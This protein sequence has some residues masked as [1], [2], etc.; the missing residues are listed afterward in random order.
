MNYMKQVANM[1]GVEVD[2]DFECYENSYKYK[3]TENGLVSSGCYG[4]DSLMMLL[5]GDLTIKRKPWKPQYGATYYCVCK[6]GYVRHEKWYCDAID[7]LYYKIGNCYKTRGEA[8]ANINKWAAFF[9]SDDVL[10]VANN[11]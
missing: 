6:Q 8:E 4:A 9:G 11:G 3:I 5:N 1:L 7:V 10:E 2:V